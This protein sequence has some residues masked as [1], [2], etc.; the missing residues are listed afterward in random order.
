MNIDVSELASSGL[1]PLS[2]GKA[3]TESLGTNSDKVFAACDI[4]DAQAGKMEG[5][6]EKL[7]T[8][9]SELT[10]NW[11]GNTAEE[12]KAKFP[13]LVSAFEEVPSSIKSISE[14]AKE[15]C[16]GYLRLDGVGTN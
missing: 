10:A 12:F 13:G 2:I 8:I 5:F 14:Y 7:T 9:Q 15:V 1:D 6:I 3:D 16:E 11:E 4:L